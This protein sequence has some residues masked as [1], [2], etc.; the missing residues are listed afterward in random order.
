MVQRGTLKI[1]FPTL[2]T[3]ATF[4]EAWVAEVLDNSPTT[5]S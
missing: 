5:N 1:A 4:K 2:F 3:I